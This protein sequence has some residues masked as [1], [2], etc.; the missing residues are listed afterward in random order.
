MHA[1]GVCRDM[2]HSVGMFYMES[3]FSGVQFSDFYCDGNMLHE[4][5]LIIDKS[6]M[7]K[8]NPGNSREN[9]YVPFQNGIN[10]S[11]SGFYP[12]RHFAFAC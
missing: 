3:I 8:K 7:C 11:A 4:L 10:E 6:K 2:A 5:S 12:S 9:C 1:L